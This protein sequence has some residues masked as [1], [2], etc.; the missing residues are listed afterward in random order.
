MRE[1]EQIV[2]SHKEWPDFCLLS[3]TT[4][5]PEREK[6]LSESVSNCSP[7]AIISPTALF[8]DFNFDT[9]SDA[10]IKQRILE[11]QNDPVKW[12]QFQF[13]FDKGLQNGEG[14]LT[15]LF[16]VTAA[17]VRGYLS[18]VD[19]EIDQ[20]NEIGAFHKKIMNKFNDKKSG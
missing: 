9:M 1:L 2:T 11:I 5:D 12:R 10:D 16:F 20:A 8:A 4:E 15:R 3:E 14:K 7:Q 6:D 17:P 18:E 13:F 19:R